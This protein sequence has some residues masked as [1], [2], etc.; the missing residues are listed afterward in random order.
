MLKLLGGTYRMFD[1]I[2]QGLERLGAHFGKI[3]QVAFGQNF[4]GHFALLALG[5]LRFPYFCDRQVQFLHPFEEFHGIKSEV[6]D[7]FY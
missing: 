7:S 6:L 4:C 1:T 3:D 2:F 5:R